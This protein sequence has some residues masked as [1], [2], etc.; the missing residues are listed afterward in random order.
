MTQVSV[1]SQEGLQSEYSDIVAQMQAAEAVDDPATLKVKDV[2][3]EGTES[4]PT[5]MMVASVTSAGYV[6]MWDTQ[7]SE[8][9]ITNR[10]M[11]PTQLRKL[12]PDGTPY[13]TTINPYKKPHRGAIKCR[14]HQDDRRRGHFDYLGYPVCPKN[15]LTSL[16]QLNRHMAH[17]HKDEWAGMELERLDQEKE[18][19]REFQRNIMLMAV[20][21]GQAPTP[22]ESAQ[23]HRVSAGTAAKK[24]QDKKLY[25]RKCDEC[26]EEFSHQGVAMVAGKKLSV[27]MKKEHGAG[28]AA[29]SS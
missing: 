17:R 5:P 11:L 6:R 8:E 10:N 15:N 22:A 1:E 18:D 24:L 20:N 12:R 7:T 27:H 21:G 25:V 4:V 13:F 29:T 3:Y 2:V 9:S 23:A 16:H 28:A 14:L 19:D 26:G